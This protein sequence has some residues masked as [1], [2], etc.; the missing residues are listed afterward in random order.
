MKGCVPKTSA[1]LLLGLLAGCA[2]GPFHRKVAVAPAAQPQPPELSQ[3]PLYSPE[4]TDGNN[5]RVPALPSAQ[6]PTVVKPPEPVVQKVKKTHKSKPPVNTARS[7]P[8]PV[9][10]SGE[11][12]SSAAASTPG[13]GNTAAAASSPAAETNV[14]TAATEKK[15]AEAQQA[16]SGAPAASP[17]GELTAGNSQEQAQTSHEAADL[18]KMTKDGVDAIKRELS[19][20]EKKTVADIR[21]FL[22]QA[23][24]ALKNGDVD[25]A[26]GLAT[27]AKI[28]LDELAPK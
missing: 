28:L 25:G 3:T 18:I 24:Q 14:P 26:Y 7:T 20:D 11:G 12:G 2:S 16:S 5:P 19:P 22:K 9:K 13:A 17:I 21:T 1:M 6:P 8:A 10:S 4:M 27:K 15:M 23:D